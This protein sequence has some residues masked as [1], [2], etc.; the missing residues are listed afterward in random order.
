M[1]I[2]RHSVWLIT[3]ASSGFGRALAG[4]VLAQGGRVIA[5]ARDPRTLT[6]LADIGGDRVMTHCLDLTTGCFITDTVEAGE[7]QFGQID[8]LVNAAGS[9]FIGSV[10][11]TSDEELHALLD[12]NLFGPIRMIRAVLPGMRR[13]HKGFIVNFSSIAGVR[14]FGGAGC[15]A[16]AKSGLESVSTALH[17]ELAP[18]GIG[19]LVVE[20]GAFRTGYAK[21]YLGYA[22][23]V[24]EDYA[25]SSGTLRKS[26]LANDGN[27]PGDPTRG[28]YAIID[29]VES[30]NPP[31]HLVLGR[32]AAQIAEQTFNERL[33]E[34]QEWRSAAES[35]DFPS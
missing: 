12:V 6:E 28:A 17:R 19:V 25:A 3:G 31:L 7:R 34:L 13:R 9:G 14:A 10:E 27:Q 32:Q 29:A 8:V 16:A 21:S 22:S 33:R 18:L 20:P 4:A 23:K 24:I 35:A 15:Y 1:R 26:V 11:E 2:G 30:E 5:T